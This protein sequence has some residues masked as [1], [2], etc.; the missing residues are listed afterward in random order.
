MRPVVLSLLAGAFVA[1]TVACA[2]E[3][4]RPGP[5]VDPTTIDR[6]IGGG[7]EAGAEGGA[8]TDASPDGGGLCNDLPVTGVLVDQSNVLGTAPAATGGA[9]T[10]GVY[11]LIDANVYTGSGGAGPTGLQI[12]ESLEISGATLDVVTVVAGKE[13]RKT[14]TFATSASGISVTETCPSSL[15]A[16]LWQ[17][18]VVGAQLTLLSVPGVGQ[19]AEN[20]YTKK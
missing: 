5:G 17:Y 6:P 15:P 10:D 2:E 12:R 13:T 16:Q 14:Y 19:T 8:T 20:V 9:I 3:K 11:D 4:V 7:L 1:L 18:S